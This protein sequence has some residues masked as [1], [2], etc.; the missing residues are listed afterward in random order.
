MFPRLREFHPRNKIVWEALLPQEDVESSVFSL[1]VFLFSSHHF[2]FFKL[3]FP[4][5]LLNS[6]NDLF[7]CCSLI[8]LFAASLSEDCFETS[9]NIVFRLPPPL[10]DAVNDLARCVMAL[11][12]TPFFCIDVCLRFLSTVCASPMTFGTFLITSRYSSKVV[13]QMRSSCV[14]MYPHTRFALPRHTSHSV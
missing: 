2:Q 12:F 13:M 9:L 6:I 8:D 3:N 7:F 14:L 11:G 4:L 1:L 5:G 10:T